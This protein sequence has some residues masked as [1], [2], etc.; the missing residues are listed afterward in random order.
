MKPRTIRAA[1]VAS[2]IMAGCAPVVDPFRISADEFRRRVK[3]VAVAHVIVPSNLGVDAATRTKFHPALEDKLRQAG[4]TVVPAQDVGEIREAKERELGGLFDPQTGKIDEAKL[5][6]LMTFVR[7][8]VKTRFSADALLLSRV[9]TVTA[10]FGYVPL[11]GVRAKWDGA[12][13]SLETGSF[14]KVVSP[15]GSGKVDALSLLV[16]IEDLNGSSLFV[17]AGGIQVLSKLAPGAGQFGGN[18]FVPVPKNELLTDPE[19]IQQAVSYAL[20]PFFK[21]ER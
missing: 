7:S 4:F 10:N 12:T 15:R 1:L 16:N 9:R 21:G 17:H 20:G 6:T 8:E 3:T 5:A 2:L 11:A 14:D 13:E 19:R 18:T